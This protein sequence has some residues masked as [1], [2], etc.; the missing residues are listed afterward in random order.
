MVNE[1]NI[2]Y[3][4]LS[5]AQDTAVDS[6]LEQVINSANPECWVKGAG[7]IY[8]KKRPPGITDELLSVPCFKAAYRQSAV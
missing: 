6:A 4:N 1:P 8:M 5:D 2:V 7:L 3:A